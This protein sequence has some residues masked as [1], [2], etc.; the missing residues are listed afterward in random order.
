MS[1]LSNASW[2]YHTDIAHEETRKT[3][4]IWKRKKRYSCC[5]PQRETI[6]RGV[7]KQFQAFLTSVLDEGEWSTSHSGRFTSGKRLGTHRTGSR[8]GPIIRPV[9]AFR[10]QKKIGFV[11]LDSNTGLFSP[12]HSA[13]A[14]LS[15]L[16]T[17]QGNKLENRNNFSGGRNGKQSRW[18]QMRTARKRR[19]ECSVTSLSQTRL[20]KEWLWYMSG[21]LILKCKRRVKLNLWSCRECLDGLLFIYLFI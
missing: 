21:I 20:T 3:V 13:P 9:S 14:I 15:R 8:V 12:K 1:H 17:V 7:Q 4:A 6:Q 16:R 2:F 18:I 5:C 10:R 11:H 19:C